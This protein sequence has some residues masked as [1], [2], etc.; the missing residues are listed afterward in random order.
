MDKHEKPR[1]SDDVNAREP[2][3][4]SRRGVLQAASVAT[5]ASVAPLASAQLLGAAAEGSDAPRTARQSSR[6][7]VEIQELQELQE[8]QDPR[9]EKLLA[10]II[11]DAWFP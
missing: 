5:L 10:R 11:L 3:L 8:P 1:R 6:R 4:L 9:V 2:G 7:D